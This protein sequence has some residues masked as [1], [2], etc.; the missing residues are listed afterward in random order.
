LQNSQSIS[1]DFSPNEIQGTI[2]SGKF[3]T[4]SEY[5]LEQNL[6][7]KIHLQRSTQQVTI[8]Y[9]AMSASMQSNLELWVSPNVT[10]NCII[11][12]QQMTLN[13][14]AQQVPFEKLKMF[15]EILTAR[16]RLRTLAP[17]DAEEMFAYRSC[18]EVIQYQSGGSKS[19]DDVIA[20]IKSMSSVELGAPGWNQLAI[21]LLSDGSLIGDCG[22]HILDDSRMTEIG[23]TL[24]PAQQSKGYAT[25]ALKA[26]LELLFVGLNKH[27]VI[28]SVDPRN[29]ASMAL[30]TR[31]GLRKE[32]H[33][34]QSLWLKG[35][36]VDDVVFAMLA[37]EWKSARE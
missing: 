28:A 31:L 19:L 35:E 9:R 4:I 16:L 14:V 29:L 23:I 22:I 1:L 15:D 6:N 2:Y 34:L 17:R 33:F 10:R 27:R 3:Q 21:E 26:V 36:W 30:M 32:G 13:A 37:R 5:T 24:A 8:C 25:E 18:P 12:S 20:F 7:R 11:L